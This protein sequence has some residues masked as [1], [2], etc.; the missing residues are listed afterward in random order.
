MIYDIFLAQKLDHG[1][2]ENLPK[3][4]FIIEIIVGFIP[5]GVSQPGSFSNS[6]T[7]IHKDYQM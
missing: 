4:N 1:N 6:L 2:N 5:G 7:V 3:S